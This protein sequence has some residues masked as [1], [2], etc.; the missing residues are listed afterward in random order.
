MAM[1]VEGRS[2][3]YLWHSILGRHWEETA[4]RCDLGGAFRS[5]VAELVDRAPG[6]VDSVWSRLPKGFPDLVASP[7]LDGL[8]ESAS[9]IAF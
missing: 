9:R 5:L 2:R 3:H 8:R 6:V 4:Q 1:A 7:I